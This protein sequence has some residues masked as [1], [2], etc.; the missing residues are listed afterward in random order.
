MLRT[1]VRSYRLNTLPLRPAFRSLSSHA[2]EQKTSV[3][4]PTTNEK[5]S[6]VQR[7]G[8]DDWKVSAPIAVALAIPILSKGIYVINEETQLAACFFLFCT[9]VYK[10]GG[11]AVSS[12]FDARAQA[13]LQEHNAVE[14]ANIEL[15]KETLKAHESLL[16]IRDDV[17]LVTEAH[18]DAVALMCQVQAYKL[19]HETRKTFIRNLDAIKSIEDECNAELKKALIRKATENVRSILV[20]GGKSTKA[21]ALKH[22]LNILSQSDMDDEKEDE[23][24]ALFAKELRSCA[25]KLEAQQGT[26]VPLTEA[27]QVAFQSELDAYKKR[28]NLTHAELKAPKEI[29]AELM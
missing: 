19:R 6:L 7:Y 16:A 21:A 9:S 15:A 2:L 3:E 22:A 24:A 12:Y 26:V 14:D 25:E 1:A 28:C 11:N 23:I 4:E 17:A 13:I 20:K 5:Q 8:L 10:F 29:T 18:K 27:E